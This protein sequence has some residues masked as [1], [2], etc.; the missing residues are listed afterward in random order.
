MNLFID[1]RTLWAVW[2]LIYNVVVIII[3]YIF[4]DKAI[5]T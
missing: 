5:I 4:L 1:S 2:L 3:K